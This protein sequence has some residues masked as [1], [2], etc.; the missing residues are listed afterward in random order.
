MK[1]L[2]ARVRADRFHP[3][4]RTLSRLLP[5]T[6]VT[7]RNLGLMRRLS[8]RGATG[9]PA[10][11]SVQVNGTASV[12]LYRPITAPARAGALLWIH[13]GGFVLGSAKEGLPLLKKMADEL[14]VV[15]AN[16]EYRLAPEHPYPAAL[17]DCYAA[18]R[19]LAARGDVDP[20][21]IAIGGGSA[22]G[23]LAAATA[24]AARDRGGPA[25]CFQLLIYPV[26]DD[27]TSARPDPDPAGRRLW[28]NRS[29][30]FAW[31]SYLGT[32]PGASDVDYL[33]APAR[34][35]DLSGLPPAWIGVGTLDLFHDEDLAYV[36]ALRE[37]RVAVTPFVVPGAYHGFDMA[38]KTEI[39]RAWRREYTS[40]LR[41][42]I[43]SAA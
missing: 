25:P 13:G 11:E 6:S 34:C 35:T 21:R 7:E 17:D 41:A 30:L 32:E 1:T 4:L 15:V 9:H 18:L 20:D 29:N 27:R 16:V 12:Q 24:L 3:D 43:G 39:V 23:G 31:R 36:R 8:E 42:A 10:F 14:G 19:W 28:N 33:A 26:L 22:G 40:A 2:M 5:R 37:A 38:T